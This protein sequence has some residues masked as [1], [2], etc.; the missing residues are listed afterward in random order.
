[1]S[2]HGIMVARTC[3]GG[4]DVFFHVAARPRGWVAPVMAPKDLSPCGHSW[5]VDLVMWSIRGPSGFLG[6]MIHISSIN[7]FG[8][9]GRH[10]NFP[11]PSRRYHVRRTWAETRCVLEVRTTSVD[12]VFADSDSGSLTS[13]KHWRMCWC[14][15]KSLSCT[16]LET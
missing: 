16:T 9:P 10:L 13:T 11:V 12:D 7:A 8:F 5:E 14:F 6:A 3:C 1:M 2:Q 4:F 15:K